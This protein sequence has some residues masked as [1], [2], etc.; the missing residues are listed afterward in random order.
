ARTGFC[1]FCADTIETATGVFD[2]AITAEGR[3][4]RGSAVVVPNVMAYS[5]FS[6]VGLYDTQSHFLDL[7]ELTPQR[8]GDLLEALTDYTRDVHGVRPMWSSLNAN[9]LPP[10]GSSLIHPHAQ[11]AH[12]DIGTTAQR[13]LVQLS[14][15]WPGASS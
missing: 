11:S 10:S 1:P 14:E 9:Y 6:S 4:R 2:P 7:P 3:I 8:V 15:A 13:R 5:E 12:D